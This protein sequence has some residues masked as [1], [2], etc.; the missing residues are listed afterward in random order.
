M[1]N[2]LNLIIVHWNTLPLL[3]KQLELLR[4]VEAEV[5]V[6]DN[7]SETSIEK[8]K[9]NFLDVTF[10]ENEVNRGF[11]FACNQGLEIAQGSWLLFLNPDTH[12]N[13]A[14]IQNLLEYAE[15]EKMVAVSPNLSAA[16]Q[17][18]V[19]SFWSVCVEYSPLHRLIPIS[20]FHPKTLP[21]ACLLIKKEV[22]EKIGGWDERFFVWFEDSDLSKRLLNGQHHFGVMKELRIAHEGASSF[23]SL[24]TNYQKEL[25]F[26]SLKIYAEK[27]FSHLKRF[28]IFFI[29]ARFMKNTL[30]PSDA[31]IAAS[32]IVP[33]MKYELLEKFLLENFAFFDFRQH[34]L[35]VVT[36]VQNTH[37]LRKKYPEVI[38]IRK[39]RQKL[40]VSHRSFMLSTVSLNRREFWYYLSA[41]Q[42][43]SKAQ[44]IPK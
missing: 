36:S 34:E 10:I 28:F 25:F 24:D 17:K 44:Q 2:K 29:V 16:Y 26:L 27:Y 4:G 5:I 1:P 32:I 13:P 3:E 12:I 30:L 18:P 40:A 42:N 15:K 38:F 6:I 11:S 43:R 14:E 19:P 23:R 22:L 7:A 41:K 37:A 35:I 9:K 31:K 33:N 20:I 8:L 39:I 21:G